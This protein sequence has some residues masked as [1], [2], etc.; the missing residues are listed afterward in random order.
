MAERYLSP[1]LRDDV[2]SI[3]S[4]HRAFRAGA[5]VLTLISCSAELGCE[6]QTTYTG[7]ER[8]D[9]TLV[10]EYAIV[11]DR[12]A[13]MQARWLEGTAGILTYAP[14]RCLIDHLQ[15]FCELAATESGRG[16]RVEDL[17]RA[18]QELSAPVPG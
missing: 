7:D 18:E 17:E 6:L 11:A 16:V 14:G 9:R 5:N 3:R 8:Q 10:G 2:A 12:P 4:D 1:T 15:R 13:S